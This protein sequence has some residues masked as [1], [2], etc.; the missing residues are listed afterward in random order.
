MTLARSNPAM[1]AGDDFL[2]IEKP[3]IEMLGPCGRSPLGG[4]SITGMK[5]IKRHVKN[6][7]EI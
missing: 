2:N 4:D 5:W 7:K 1:K 3:P 6:C